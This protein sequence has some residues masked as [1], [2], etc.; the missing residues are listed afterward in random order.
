M[1][2]YF[3]NHLN[4]LFE[5]QKVTGPGRKS[6]WSINDAIYKDGAVRFISPIDP[7]F[8]CLPILEK[9][10][11]DNQFR[12]LDD[13]FTR[14]NVEIEGEDGEMDI[15]RLANIVPI[16]QLAHVCD[17]K[18][19]GVAV[20]RLNNDLVLDWLV[21]KVDRLIV[22][23]SFVKTFKQ[24]GLEQEHLKLDA[25]YTLANYLTNTWFTKLLDKLGLK[26]IEKEKGSL[27]EY[28]TDT[29]PASYFKRPNYDELM[30][31]RDSPAKKIKPAVPRSLAKV[32]TKGMKTLTSFFPKK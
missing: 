1:A 16:E 3:H 31:D 22:N 19:V 8:V 9:A 25:V 26:E 24:T 28:A 2:V 29:S 21:K 7:L 32:N 15:H 27:T 23:A 18:D 4:Q 20:Y 5:I 17:S 30:M 6:S 10:S 13:V 14:E 12:T 11:L